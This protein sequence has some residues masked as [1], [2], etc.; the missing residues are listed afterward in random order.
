MGALGKGID[1]MPFGV[2]HKYPVSYSE[3]ALIQGKQCL[4]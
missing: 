3:R 2:K 1:G 4:F